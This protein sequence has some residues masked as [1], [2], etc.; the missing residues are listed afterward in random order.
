MLKILSELN[1]YNIIFLVLC[2]V[3]SCPICSKYCAMTEMII[4]DT[5]SWI[6]NAVRSYSWKVY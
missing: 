2:E 6:E 1:R 4:R 5:S 3:V